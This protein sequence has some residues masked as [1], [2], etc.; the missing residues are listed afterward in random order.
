M[1]VWDRCA[2]DF[3]FPLL[4]NGYVY[5]AATRLSLYASPDDWAMC[6]EVFGFSP[7]S[8][9]PDVTLYTFGS[10]VLRSKRVTD[11][12]SST[13]YDNYLST[14]PFNECTF[15]Y[16]IEA[17]DWQDAQ[18]DELMASGSH[19]VVVRGASIRTPAIDEYAHVGISLQGTGVVHVFEFCR[20][21]AERHRHLV[22]ATE[23]ERRRCIRPELRLLL[24]LNDWHHPDLASG[25]LPSAT[26]TFPY[27][28]KVL[29]GE[30][31]AESYVPASVNTH[32][33]HWPEAGTL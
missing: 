9:D 28:A 6:I 12:V 3:N 19:E 27:L 33:S 26:G 5:S 22:L 1:S 24:T 15:V 32:W 7:R 31:R 20:L 2:E 17:G 30:E 29:A 13:A 23:G 8:G 25:E 4:D 10:N 11:F 21:L 18:N 16:P 14:H